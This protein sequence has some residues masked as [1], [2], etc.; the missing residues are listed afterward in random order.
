MDNKDIVP[1][2]DAQRA[3]QLV[4]MNAKVWNINPKKVG[5]LG[6]SAGGHVASTAGTHFLKEKIDNPTHISL[7]PDF[8]ILNYPVI[9]FA[10]SIVHLASRYNLISGDL[11][12]P[13]VNKILSNASELKKAVVSPEKVI[14]YSNELHVTANTPPTFITHSVDDKTVPIQNSLLFI[15]ALQKNKVPVESFFYAKG[16]HGYGMYNSTSDVNW[17][18][19]C[20]TWILKR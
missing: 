11:A 3:I 1:L 17:I 10:D 4:R 19:S 13:E 2:Q 16:G 14:E 8:L 15:A 6:N 20:I 7:R 12:Y 9:S 18:D 5:I